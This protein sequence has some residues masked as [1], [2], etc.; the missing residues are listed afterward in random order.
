MESLQ[1]EIDSIMSNNDLSKKE[2]F[3][4]LRKL[5][6]DSGTVGKTYCYC[7]ARMLVDPEYKERFYRKNRKYTS[8]RMKNDPEFRKRANRCSAECAVRRYNSDAEYRE[9]QKEISRDRYNR[10]AEYREHRKIQSL[11]RYHMSKAT[12]SEK[13]DKNAVSVRIDDMMGALRI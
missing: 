2:Q 10:N 12:F 1:P 4:L 13:V 6:E 5:F 11:E 3:D 9:R 8:N 7:K